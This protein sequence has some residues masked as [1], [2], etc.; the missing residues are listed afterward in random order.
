MGCFWGAQRTFWTLPGVCTTA[1]GC[2]GEMT[3]DQPDL[4]RGLRRPDRAP[5][6]HAR[7][8]LRHRLGGTWCRAPR[9]G[10]RRPGERRRCRPPDGGRTAAATCGNARGLRP[11]AV[12]E[13][14]GLQVERYEPDDVATRL[15]FRIE[16]SNDGSTYHGG[17]VGAVIDTTGA[18]AAWSNHDFE[19]GMRAST[20]SMAVQYVAAG[21]GS[22][23]CC[24]ATDGSPG[25]G[26]D[27]HRD[28]G[29]RRW[30]ARSW[31]TDS[32]PTGSP[33]AV[34][35]AGQLSAAGQAV[36][37]RL[38]LGDEPPHQLAGRHELGDRADALAGRVALLVDVDALGEGVAAEVHRPRFRR[39]RPTARGT[40]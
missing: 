40:S 2:A 37:D 28:H 34:P 5:S 38:G 27:L 20:V 6:A 17:V 4:L 21:A 22:D 33:D 10:S 16:L 39:R 35:A 29:D 9:W 32:R 3:P 12:P 31:P 14:L 19:R 26:T 15:P 13:W 8:L 1:V 7:P 11:D 18:L 30:P 36:E 23:L 25:P 24:T